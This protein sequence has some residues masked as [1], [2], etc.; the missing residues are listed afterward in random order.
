MKRHLQDSVDTGQ[1]FQP[2]RDQLEPSVAM[3]I[4][5]SSVY[6]VRGKNSRASTR[7]STKNGSRKTKKKLSNFK[8]TKL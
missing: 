6:N 7:T 5:K 8:N 1:H 4:P 3:E 2:I